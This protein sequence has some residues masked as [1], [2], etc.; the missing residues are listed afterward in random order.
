MAY[1]LA[2][3]AEQQIEDIPFKSARRFGMTAVRYGLL[4]NAVMVVL[5]DTPLLVG[6][7][8]ISG[9]PGI[10]IYPLRLGR[11]LVQPAG[12][13]VRRPRHLVVYRVGPDRVTEILGFAHDRMLLPRAA[14]RMTKAVHGA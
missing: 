3:S 12:Q 9:A 5:G 8:A 11:D 7:D 10:R 13:R 6:S 14:R 2:G 4:I 1:R